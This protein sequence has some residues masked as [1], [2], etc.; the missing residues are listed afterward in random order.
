M[1]EL[2]NVI[3]KVLVIEEKLRVAEEKSMSESFGLFGEKKRV[4]G[5]CFGELC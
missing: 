4:R 5:S 3:E 2:Y 1:S